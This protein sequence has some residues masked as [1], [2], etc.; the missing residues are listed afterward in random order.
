MSP[1]LRPATRAAAL[2]AS[3]LTGLAMCV[4]A[5]A[6]AA[7]PNKHHGSWDRT[8]SDSAIAP[9]QLS[10][11]H[12][13]V[14]ATDGFAGTL[15][16]YDKRGAPTVLATNPGGE[17]AGVDVS[18]DGRS[19]AFVGGGEAGSWMKIRTKGKAEV[20]VDLSAYES[21]VNPDG[22][23]TYGIIAGGNPCAEAALG[24]LTHG[25]ATYTGIVESHPY[26]VAWLGH[27]AWAVADAAGNDILRVSSSGRIS[28]LAILP[29]QEITI[30]ATMATGLRLPDCVVGVRY[31]FEPVPTDVERGHRGTLWVSSLPGGPEDASLGA[32][33]SV[34][35][36]G[37]HGSVRK[38]ATGFLGATDLAVARNGTVYVAELFGGRFTAFDGRHRWTAKRL[39][40][41]LSVEVAGNSLYV[42]TLATIDFG[43]GQ[44]LAPGSIL[45]LRR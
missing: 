17:I 13:S 40:N 42:G 3:A 41:P 29:R 34:F 6:D 15:T 14:Y 2:T 45:R 4:A 38:V 44:V 12:G 25:R 31:A 21:R 36:V 20:T 33:G 37:A 7:A 30:T 39:N 16:R 28:T 1:T 19:Y 9:F 18:P 23:V 11:N 43:T 8:I 32:R 10:V 24:E 22:N 5:P 26:A 35:T 27:G